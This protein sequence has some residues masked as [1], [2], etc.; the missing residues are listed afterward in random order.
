MKSIFQVVD[1]QLYQQNID[2][3]DTV[4]DGWTEDLESLQPQI[5]PEAKSEV[6]ILKEELEANKQELLQTQLAMAEMFE[7]MMS[8]GP[9]A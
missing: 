5:T 8:G 9:N 6:D 2:E 3:F 4:P 1:G 7:Q